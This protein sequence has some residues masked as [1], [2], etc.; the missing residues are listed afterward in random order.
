VERASTFERPDG[1]RLALRTW[2][3]AAG[4]NASVVLLHG[5]GEHI[6]RYERLAGALQ[7]AGVAVYGFDKRGH[8]RSLG[9]RARFGSLEPLIQDA[10]A[11]V[12]AVREEQRGPWA[13]FGH[14]LGG[15][16]A[17]RAVQDGSLRPDALV[18]SSPWL[19]RPNMPR[20]ALQRLLLAF[21]NVAP[22]LPAQ[23]LE[24][25]DMSRDPVAV[26]AYRDDP[27]I[28]HGSVRLETAAA[29][30]RSARDALAADQPPLQV[31]T[32]VLH[33]SADIVADP[34][35]A[36]ALARRNPGTTLHLEPEGQHELFHDTCREFVTQQL[37]RWLEVRLNGH[38]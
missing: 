29:M 31:P 14:S 25:Q 10:A 15:L 2:R 34:A 30:L 26:A 24:P 1:M 9:P 38:A 19:G 22:W 4:G 27:L 8:G 36:E 17:L 6:G 5:L 28:Y 13:L 23:R 21:A 12:S 16:V 3:P 11:V 20:P 37:L 32:L 18:L 33:G 35:A 7:R